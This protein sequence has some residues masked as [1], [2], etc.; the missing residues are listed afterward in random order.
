VAVKNNCQNQKKV[1]EK[2]KNTL[3]GVAFQTSTGNKYT[4]LPEV[5]HSDWE[6][7]FNP[8]LKKTDSWNNEDEYTDVS[9]SE[10]DN[11]HGKIK[12]AKA[13]EPEAEMKNSAAY[14]MLL[15]MGFRE[16]H[17]LG[18]Q[19][20]GI[21]APLVTQAKCERNGLGFESNPVI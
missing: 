18:K 20:Q 14:K 17:G 6:L 9:D 21:K 1:V 8:I 3:V 7:K 12:L 10:G 2:E 4:G 5:K 11:K 19:L 13:D 15:K 16:G